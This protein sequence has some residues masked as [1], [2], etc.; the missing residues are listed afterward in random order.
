MTPAPFSPPALAEIIQEELAELNQRDCPRL[1]GELRDSYRLYA[2]AV[3]RDARLM[4]PQDW[5]AVQ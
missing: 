4:P 3:M 1:R 2:W 5:Q